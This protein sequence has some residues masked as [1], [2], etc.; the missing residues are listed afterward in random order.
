MLSSKRGKV[1]YI[2]YQTDIK[3]PTG[4]YKQKWQSCPGMTFKEAQALLRDIEN[5]R[6]RGEPVGMAD[7]LMTDYLR[8]WLTSVKMTVAPTTYR[9]YQNAVERHLI[10]G[11]GTHILAKLTPATI[12]KLYVKLAESLAPKTV[13]NIHCVLHRAL[14]QAMRWKLRVNNPA[15]LVDPPKTE[16]SE[17]RIAEPQ[18]LRMILRALH[19][20]E[21]YLPTLIALATGMRRGEVLALQW[22][23]FDEDGMVLIVRRAL[24]CPGQ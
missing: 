17:I 21:W 4:K 19:G 5:R 3:L 18:Q 13:K 7:Q 23:D 8:D 20:R 10:H 22:R 15:A 16:R 6:D 9:E 12:Q 2:A 24:A 14:E 11:L 1:W